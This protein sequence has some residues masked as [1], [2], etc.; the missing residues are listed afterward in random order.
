MLSSSLQLGAHLTPWKAGRRATP[1][2]RE[3]AR[4]PVPALGPGT[5][6]H[7]WKRGLIS[8]PTGRAGQERPRP[9]PRPPSSRVVLHF[10][11]QTAP[12][13]RPPAEGRVLGWALHLQRPR[14]VATRPGPPHGGGDGAPRSTATPPGLCGCD[15][16][17]G[18]CD[19][20]KVTG[21]ERALTVGGHSAPA[22][23][24]C[25]QSRKRSSENDSSR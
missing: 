18:C 23:S 9:C 12:A 7:A 24:S 6:G 13:G 11:T 14:A 8:S 1:T 5:G 16:E 2:G 25:S 20:D 22:D 19:L 17:T 15:Y 4:V 10:V 21:G 3:D